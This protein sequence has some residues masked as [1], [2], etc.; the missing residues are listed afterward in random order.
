M[1]KGGLY[2]DHVIRLVRS[3]KARFP[4]RSVHEQISVDGNTGYL[5]NALDHFAYRSIGEYWKKANAYILLTADEM[6]RSGVKPGISS[7]FAYMVIK[8]L[9]TFLS[10]Y[11]RHKGFLDGWQ[12]L[13]FA[14]FS[15]LHYPYAYGKYR[16]LNNI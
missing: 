6:K 16:S 14:Y 13:V 12:G 4:C 9:Y 10:L 15:A 7:W 5:V 2:P 3:G 1:K 8:P 11:L